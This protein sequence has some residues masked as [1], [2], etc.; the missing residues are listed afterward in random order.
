MVLSVKLEREGE[1]LSSG[2]IWGFHVSPWIGAE[3]GGPREVSLWTTSGTGGPKVNVNLDRGEL[4]GRVSAELGTTGIQP[5]DPAVS[6]EE[7]VLD[8]PAERGHLGRPSH[9][10]C[11]GPWITLAFIGLHCS[12]PV[13]HGDSTAAVDRAQVA[14]CPPETSHGL[15]FTPHLACLLQPGSPL[16]GPSGPLLL[17]LSPLP[18]LRSL[19]GG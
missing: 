9:Q 11:S 13:G 10:P 14:C 6:A 1:R 5:R 2:D 18:L 19:P 15:A 7:R 3:W 8:T 12:Q 17:H 4:F 16:V